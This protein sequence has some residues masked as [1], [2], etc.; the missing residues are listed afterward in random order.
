MPTKRSSWPGNLLYYMEP[1]GVAMYLKKAWKQCGD[2]EPW[3]R[4]NAV[5]PSRPRWPCPEEM[6]DAEET[7]AVVEDH[8][9]QMLIVRPRLRRGKGEERHLCFEVEHT[10]PTMDH[11]SME[12]DHSEM[13]TPDTAVEMLL[14]RLRSESP[15]AEVVAEETELPAGMAD[16]GHLWDDEFIHNAFGENHTNKY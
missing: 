5:E 6:G 7:P 1:L 10:E 2:Y 3:F 4:Y 12:M 8:H 11:S 16:L 14:T 9:G 15:E 13:D